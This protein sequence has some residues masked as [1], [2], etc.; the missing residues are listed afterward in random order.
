MGINVTLLSHQEHWGHTWC[1]LAV[2]VCAQPRPPSSHGFS[3]S[4]SCGPFICGHLSQDKDRLNP[5]WSHLQNLSKISS[6]CRGRE[7]IWR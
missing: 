3:A 1:P 6:V 7:V 5:G 2:V 4:L